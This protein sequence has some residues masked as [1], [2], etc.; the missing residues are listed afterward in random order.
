MKNKPIFIRVFGDTPKIRILNCMLKYRGLDYSMSDIA[1]NSKV[2][3]ATLSR[4]WKEFIKLKVV[5]FT[6]KI[7]RAK[8]YKINEE[9]LAVQEL[10]NVYKALLV[11]ETKNYF[12]QKEPIS[13]RD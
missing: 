11:Q 2:G 12:R 5:V 7:G 6:R 4:L 10:I 3:W 1:R 9:N 8:L 13:I